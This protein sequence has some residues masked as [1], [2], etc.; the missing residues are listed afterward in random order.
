M[1]RAP[2]W[3]PTNQTWLTSVTTGHGCAF[4]SVLGGF[5]M[6]ERK[7]T[8]CSSS[9]TAWRNVRT[10]PFVR[11]FESAFALNAPTELTVSLRRKACA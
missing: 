7:R 8:R 6:F 10:E 9:A 2:Q 1:D 4:G 11:V 5:H 3:P